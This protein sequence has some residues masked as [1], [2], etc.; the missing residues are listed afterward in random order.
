MCWIYMATQNIK[1]AC[2]YNIWDGEELLL[3]SIRRMR[4]LASKI[5]VVYS[6]TSN[7]GETNPGLMS[8]IKQIEDEGLADEI[9][10][11]FTRKG[12]A[13]QNEI[14]K[15]NLGLEKCADCDVFM[16]MD[17]DE[18]YHMDELS[19]MLTL[20]WSA[21]YDSS[22]C[23]MQTYYKHPDVRIVPPEDYYVPLFYR[24]DKRKFVLSQKWPVVSDPT[25]KMLPGKMLII[26]RG[27]MEMH[28][29]SYVRKDVRRKLRNSSAGNFADRMEEIAQWHDDWTDDGKAYFAG[30]Q[31]RMY[32]TERVQLPF[33]ELINIA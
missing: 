1:L 32:E 29:F 4:G 10:Q 22:A 6:N 25:R 5:V 11:Y 19:H 15:R 21:G 28:H 26:E 16:T 20:F 8:V 13:H 30:S 23:Q 9:V 12:S 3:P 31:V 17:C 24:V 27:G 14:A 18:F 2:C 7:T 33:P